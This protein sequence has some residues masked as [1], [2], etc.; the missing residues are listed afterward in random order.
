MDLYKLLRKDWQT[1]KPYKPGEQ[2]ANPEEWVKLNT[3]EN[4]YPPPQEV[5]D[6]IRQAIDGTLRLYPD[7][8]AQDLRKM[9]SSVLLPEFRTI[10]GV[11][12]V[13]VGLG[14]DEI[15]DILLKTFI[16]P[17]DEVVY[18][19][20]SYGMY[21]VLAKLYG[22]K[23]T[24]IPLAGDFSIPEDAMTKFPEKAKLLF[25][26]SPNNPNGKSTDNDSI[27][28]MCKKF[29]GIVV[30]DEAYADFAP[31]SALSL[32][33]RQKNLIVV[34]TFSKS[35][36][37]AGIRAGFLVASPEIVKELSRAKLPFNVPYLSQVA[38]VAAIK[39]RKKQAELNQ[40]IIDERTRLIGELSTYPQLAVLNSDANFVFTKFPDQ[41]TAMKFFWELKKKK[42]LVRQFTQRGLY[43]YIRVTVGTI[44]QNDK[45]L[46][47][48]A[49]IAQE[50]LK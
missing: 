22:A 36:S 1:K 10:S 44:E 2:P 20:P 26:C 14:S 17:G 34:R 13:L 5:L 33:K 8:T 16:D 4:P 9:I 11:N 6:D 27:T 7:P 18:F 48:F 32:L 15:L 46:Q 37:M 12:S 25:L 38:A 50:H 28:A 31:T 41:A 35:Y 19:T 43:E 30:V 39:H 42:I 29:P 23:T 24:E 45:F 21:S 3:N 40:K 49:E 47:A